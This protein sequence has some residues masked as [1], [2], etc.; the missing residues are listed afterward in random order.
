MVRKARREGRGS[1]AWRPLCGLILIIAQV[2]LRV[3]RALLALGLG[4]GMVA[5]PSIGL[6]IL[7]LGGDVLEVLA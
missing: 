4:V 1:V 3:I 5:W 7:R 2:R 6:A